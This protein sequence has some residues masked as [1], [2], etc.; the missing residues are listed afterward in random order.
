MC[1]RV[2]KISS[3]FTHASTCLLRKAPCTHSDVSGRHICGTMV[4]NDCRNFTI[5]NSMAVRLVMT[6]LQQD[7]AWS[8]TLNP[9]EQLVQLKRLTRYAPTLDP[10]AFVCEEVSILRNVQF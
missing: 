2:R 6:A 5:Q 4:Q 10:R 8:A 1:Q 3:R 9:E 7:A